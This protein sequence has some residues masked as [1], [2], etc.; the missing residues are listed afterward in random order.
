[1]RALPLLLLLAI[2]QIAVMWLFYVAEL[3]AMR[4]AR[5]SEHEADAAAAR[6]GYSR[7]LADAYDALA[8]HEVEPA[9]RLARLMADHPPLGG[10][11]ERLRDYP[12]PS[13]PTT[14]VPASMS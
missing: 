14:T 7:P 10:R 13:D 11:I 4:A 2:W 1:V 5:I 9:G 3:L 8:G 6:W 12:V